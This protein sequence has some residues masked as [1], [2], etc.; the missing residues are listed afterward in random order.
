MMFTNS[1]C[2]LSDHWR[3][4]MMKQSWY[5]FKYCVLVFALTQPNLLLAHSDLTLVNFGGN[6]ARA[7]MLVLLRPWEADNNAFTTM[8]EYNGGIEEIRRQV[9]TANVTWDVILSLIHI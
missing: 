3:E 9:N 5:F 4:L 1:S 6:A 2:K 7:Q 8:E